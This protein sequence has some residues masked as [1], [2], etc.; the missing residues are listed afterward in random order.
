[1]SADRPTDTLI[2]ASQ[3]DRRVLASTHLRMYAEMVSRSPMEAVT[4]VVDRW[5]DGDV[6]DRTKLD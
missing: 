1:M 6:Q 3:R 5:T 2:D 4:A